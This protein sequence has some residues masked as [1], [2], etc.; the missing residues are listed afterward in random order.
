LDVDARI[1]QMAQGQTPQGT[2]PWSYGEGTAGYIQPWALR[3]APSP[4][5]PTTQN[6]LRKQDR[7][8]RHADF[9]VAA[10]SGFPLRGHALKAKHSNHRM[11]APIKPVAEVNKPSVHED[12]R[13]FGLQP[14][15]RVGSDLLGPL[16]PL[17]RPASKPLKLPKTPSAPALLEPRH[18]SISPVKSFIESPAGHP[19]ARLPTRSA[20]KPSQYSRAAPHRLDLANPNNLSERL[21]KQ[22]GAEMDELSAAAAESAAESVST[23]WRSAFQQDCVHELEA[24]E[25]GIRY[26]KAKLRSLYAAAARPGLSQSEAIVLR[27]ISKYEVRIARL[28]EARGRLAKHVQPP[29][30][31]LPASGWT[32]WPLESAHPGAQGEEHTSATHRNIRARSG[33]RVRCVATVRSMLSHVTR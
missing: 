4:T 11:Q 12:E 21:S 20:L 19:W 29:S 10:S 13:L 5:Q 23:E 2:D 30:I 18:I 1:A 27:H 31:V 15:I 6:W 7:V 22:E 3:R 8:Q 25:N 26:A 28:E 16:A 32:S 9:R 14:L 24:V 17:T 33:M